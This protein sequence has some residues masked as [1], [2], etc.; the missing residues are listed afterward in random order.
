M[1]ILLYEEEKV[2]LNKLFAL[3][4]CSFNFAVINKKDFTK[5]IF[6]QLRKKLNVYEQAYWDHT[7]TVYSLNVNQMLVQK[8]NTDLE[9]ADTKHLKKTARQRL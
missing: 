4:F 8:L 9:N 7:T 1:E 6:Q 2:G 3:H 5:R